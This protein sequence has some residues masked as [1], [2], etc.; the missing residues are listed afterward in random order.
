MKKIII[1]LSVIVFLA[2][3]IMALT[4]EE[5]LKKV[6]SNQVFKTIKYSGVMTIKKGRRRKPRVKTFKAVAMGKDRAYI[7]FTNPG[8]RGTKYLKLGDEFWV[9]GAYA[10][11]P[12]KISGHKLRESMMGSDYSYEDTMDNEKLIDR[13]NVK[14]LGMEKIS[15]ADCYKLELTAKVKVIS[16]PRQLLWVDKKKFVAMKVQYFA[17]S[18]VLLK[19]LTIEGVKKIKNR[20]FPVKIKMENKQR[21]DSYTIFEMKTIELDEPIS[22]SIFSKK[23]LER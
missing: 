20:Y 4:P 6:D 18:G 17:L 23:Q 9:K 13:Y 16:Y 10:E 19:E 15:G 11:R 12:D 1:A 21:D 2:G 22:K 7:E 5:I 3:E 8:D 14:L